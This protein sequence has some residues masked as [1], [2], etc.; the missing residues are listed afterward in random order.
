MYDLDVT[1]QSRAQLFGLLPE[2]FAVY[3]AL[4]ANPHPEIAREL[5]EGGCRAEI[6]STGELANA[7]TAGF[8]PE[9][10]LYTGPG[11][12]DGELD[13]AI[14]MRRPVVLRGIAD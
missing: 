10:I 13:T 2:G 14:A 4:K 11:K 5:R 9:D 6:S 1:A 7:L 3:Y 8:A 12:T